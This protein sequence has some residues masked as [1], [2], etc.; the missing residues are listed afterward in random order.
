MVIKSF[1]IIWFHSDV[2][3]MTGSIFPINVF[4]WSF[5]LPIIDVITKTVFAQHCSQ[6]PIGLREQG[7]MQHW[8]PNSD[9][10]Y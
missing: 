6:A 2:L 4:L 3:D 9:W 10:E 1:S 8:M 5:Q 7:Q